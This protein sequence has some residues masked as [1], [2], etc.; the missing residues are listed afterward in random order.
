MLRGF[1]VIFLLCGIAILAVLGFRGRIST[2]PP[3]EVFPDMVRQPKVR[4]QAPLDLFADGRRS[5]APARRVG[6][7]DEQLAAMGDAGLKPLHRCDQRPAGALGEPL[8]PFAV[9]CDGV[10]LRLRVG[11]FR[12]L[13]PD[14]EANK[15]FAPVAQQ[16]AGR[17]RDA[18]ADR[19]AAA[20]PAPPVRAVPA[21]SGRR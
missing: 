10:A 12:R 4:A 11:E 6:Q 20:A 2:Q 9:A 3:F 1:L 18:L 16:G 15:A 8:R 17:E 21:A 13:Q 5:H 14:L 19:S 7:R